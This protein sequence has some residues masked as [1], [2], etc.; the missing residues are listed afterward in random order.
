MFSITV[1]AS[2]SPYPQ[3][4]VPGYTDVLNGSACLTVQ[5]PAGIFN[6]HA[7]HICANFNLINRLADAFGFEL[8][9]ARGLARSDEFLLTRGYQ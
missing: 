8:P 2:A 1:D 6:F 5:L 3:F 9:S 7:I 4:Q